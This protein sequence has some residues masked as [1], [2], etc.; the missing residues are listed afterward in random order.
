MQSVKSIPLYLDN[1][2][3][4]IGEEGLIVMDNL[5]QANMIQPALLNQAFYWRV[6]PGMLNG[7]YD[8]QIVHAHQHRRTLLAFLDA[9]GFYRGECEKHNR[10]AW[11]AFVRKNFNEESILI[12]FSPGSKPNGALNWS[13][14]YF[15]HEEN[16]IIFVNS[17]ESFFNLYS[18]C[19]GVCN[20]S[21]I[22]NGM[23]GS[24]SAYQCSH[25]NLDCTVLIGG[26]FDES[27]KDLIDKKLPSLRLCEHERK[28]E[29]YELMDE[30]MKLTYAQQL[31]LIGQQVSKN[32]IFLSQIKEL[33]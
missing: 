2:L 14:D 1:R 32:R 24:L 21:D 15:L 30:D 23:G 18:T 13:R 33:F 28:E 22:C 16:G 31:H 6:R 3:L 10:F 17:S 25:A 29:Y 12:K 7:S 11:H 26:Q 9:D 5:I 20:I 27:T 4:I 19:G 8:Q